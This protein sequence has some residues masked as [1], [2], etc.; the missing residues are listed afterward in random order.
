MATTTKTIEIYLWLLERTETAY[1][2]EWAKCIVAGTTAEQARQI[3]NEDSGAEGYVWTDGSLTQ[4]KRLGIADD[5]V[6]GVV[7]FA[8]E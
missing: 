1:S 3:A 2:G 8:G 4:I 6:Q 7:L 5:G